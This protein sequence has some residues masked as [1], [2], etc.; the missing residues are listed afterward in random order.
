MKDFLIGLLIAYIG[1]AGSAY[2]Y[3]IDVKMD[4]FVKALTNPFVFGVAVGAFLVL[5]F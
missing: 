3:Y 1:L 2:L 4:N 5:V